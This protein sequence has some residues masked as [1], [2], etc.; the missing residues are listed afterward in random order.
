M[1]K[2][3]DEIAISI[4]FPRAL[5][6]QLRALAEAEHRSVNGTVLTA[7]E[8]YLRQMSARRAKDSTDR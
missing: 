8:R 2:R 4:R 1:P 6:E 5:L 3:D 7:V